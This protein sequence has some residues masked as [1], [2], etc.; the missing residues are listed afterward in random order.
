MRKIKLFL[1]LLFISFSSFVGAGLPYLYVNLHPYPCGM[2]SVF[3]YVAGVLYEYDTNGYAGIEV[4]FENFGLYF[5]ANYGSNWWEYY[6]EPIRIGNKN[7]AQLKE[8]DL[9]EYESYAYF[10]QRELD[11]HQVNELIQKYIRI[12]KPIQN[13]IDNFV[14]SN[15]DGQHIIGVHY[16][17]TDKVIEAPRVTYDEMLSCVKDYISK[18]NFREYKIFVASDE[19]QF[20]DFMRKAF[21]GTV[22]TYSSQYSMDGKPLHR[23]STNNFLQGEE[24]LIDCLL[25]S[26][27]DVLI[28]TSSNL[29]LWSTYFNPFLLSIEL[30]DRY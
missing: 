22:V 28:R 6:C 21:P 25:L 26:R 18:G 12:K 29:S 5:D 20:V 8:F 17:G 16:R 23:N 3:S 30:N 24:A 27:G 2:F 15:F 13:K 19:I 10:L 7:Q 11:R 14:H 1:C 4:N 9:K